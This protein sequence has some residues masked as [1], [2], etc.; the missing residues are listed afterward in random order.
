MP[1]K[2]GKSGN[3]LGRPIGAKGKN[4][5]REFITDFLEENKDRIKIDFELL[6]PKDRIV[7]FEKL[8]KYSLPTL[9]ATSLSTN[10]DRLSDIE[11]DIIIQELKQAQ[12]MNREV[13]IALLKGI[14][15]GVLTKE[16]LE[17]PQ[18]YI[19]FGEVNNSFPGIKQKTYT[20]RGKVYTDEERI[21][22]IAD[23]EKKNDVLTKL[24]VFKK[25]NELLSSHITIVF[26]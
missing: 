7:L 23:I 14:K 2:K 18:V 26:E 5:L 20:M 21:D 10:L 3:T 9:Q 25:S 13:K 24:G 19:F 16:H 4:N 12:N 6:E 1:F 22:F 17:P 11:L 15:E 8:L